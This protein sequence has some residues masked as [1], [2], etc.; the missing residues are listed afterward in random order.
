MKFYQQRRVLEYFMYPLDWEIKLKIP[1]FSCSFIVYFCLSRMTINAE[2]QLQL[3]NFP[4]DEHSCPLVF[5]SCEYWHHTHGHM[6]V[7]GQ[8]GQKIWKA[9]PCVW[10]KMR[11][12]MLKIR[13]QLNINLMQAGAAQIM[14]MCFLFRKI[15]FLD[16]AVTQ[17]FVCS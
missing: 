8:K 5:S 7:E 12:S 4:M 13:A 9:A 6:S 1:F 2:C 14:K 11:M 15:K 3:H 16:K 10:A 17:T